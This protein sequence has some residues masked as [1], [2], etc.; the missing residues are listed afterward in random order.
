MLNI[1]L[2]EARLLPARIF[3]SFLLNYT[4][5]FDEQDQFVHYYHPILF[6]PIPIY[7]I[8]SSHLFHW[9]KITL[10]LI[11]AFGH[12]PTGLALYFAL[13]RR[14]GLMEKGEGNRT[15]KTGDPA[16]SQR[17]NSFQKPGNLEHG[18]VRKSAAGKSTSN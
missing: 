15:G 2:A 17:M 13:S 4:I 9:N 1:Y 16:R 3:F 12:H 8:P 11:L 10:L 7:F 5:Y 18:S 6:H 14:M